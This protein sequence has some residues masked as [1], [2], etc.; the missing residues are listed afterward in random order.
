MLGYSAKLRIGAAAL[1]ALGSAMVA[2]AACQY[3]A[4]TETRQLN[5]EAIGVCALP[6]GKGLP[7]VR[8][9][10]FVPT[11]DVVDI[12]IKP[13]SSGSW[14][15]PLILSGGTKC[16]SQFSSSKTE[17]PGYS[18][19]PGFS[20]G[21]VTVPF[22][23]P[24]S[25]VDV[26]IVAAGSSCSNNV[27]TELD[28]AKLDAHAIT[29]LLRIG[30]GGKVPEKLEAKPENYPPNLSNTYIRFVNVLPGSTPLDFGLAPSGTLQL[31]TTVATQILPTPSGA[32]VGVAFGDTA[33]VGF[34]ALTGNL[35]TSAGYIPIIA[36]TF[37]LAV[38]VNGESPE[39]AIMFLLTT[40]MNGS[41]FSFY[42]A[43]VLPRNNNY[44]E[45][46]FF[47][48]ESSSPPP[49]VTGNPLLVQCTKTRL[50]GISVDVFT[51]SLFG[52]NSPGYLQ[53]KAAIT[54]AMTSPVQLR[55]SDIMCFSE[56]DFASDIQQI[57][58]NALPVDAGGTGSFP[59]NYWVKTTL[60]T[61]FSDSTTQDGGMPPD[62]YP[63]PCGN[64]PMATWQAA[65][66]CMEKNCSSTGDQNGTLPGSTDCFSAYCSSAL[67][68]LLLQT[69]YNACFDCIIDF[70][71]SDQT[72]SAGQTACTMTPAPPFG[73]DGQLSNMILSRYPLL[74]TKSYI[75]PSTNYR[76]GA[77]YAQV[78]LEDQTVDFYCTFLQ[79]TLIASEQPYTG[80]YGNG[81]NPVSESSGGAYANEQLWEAQKFIDWVKATSGASGNP[82][83]VVGDWRSSLAGPADAGP[84]NPEAGI[85]TSPTAL[86][87]ETQNLL[88]AQGNFIP[89]SAPDWIPQCTYCPQGDNP[90]NVGQAQGYF[91]LQPYLYNWPQNMVQ[92]AVQTEQLIYTQP[93]QD[94]LFN[95]AYAPLS[96]YFGLNFQIVRPKQ[97][98]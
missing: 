41:S 66:A 31:P 79:T 33:P 24:G 88:S 67:G 43:G 97:V 83:I 34:R 92:A 37:P 71:A 29:T 61:P 1:A 20:Y 22:S 14:G 58:H 85:F 59:Y 12:C 48:D 78:Q 87:P 7:Q 9:A 40:E 82:A 15:E 89:V 65:Y 17:P 86:V 98:Q 60:A 56:L 64:V 47:C 35:V 49:T 90:L 55:D 94:V 63:V 91:M 13:S 10:N 32:G 77:L 73:F 52:P 3:I 75:F 95:D 57:V 21:Q 45:Q 26:R 28:G 74:N 11:A 23:A 30:G 4:G 8:F 93:S 42:A 2:L 25:V 44:P 80:Y 5:P 81:G 84:S 53:R 54:N 69:Q 18:G 50:N 96:Q 38:G 27:L 19:P 39:K 70:A 51:T 36:G 72:Y 16:P 68:P 6:S 62:P 76:Q 46:G